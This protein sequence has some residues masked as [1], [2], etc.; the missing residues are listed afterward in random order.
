M[1][2]GENFSLN[3]GTDRNGLGFGPETGRGYEVGIAANLPGV[4]VAATWFDIRKQAI[5]TTDPVDANYLAPVGNLVSRGIEL[6]ASARLGERWQIVANYA[7]LDAKADDAAFPTP[8]VL[9]VPEHS[10]T[11]LVVHRIPTARGNWQLSGGVAYVGDRAG[12]LTAAPVIL[13]EYVKVKA[14]IEAPLAEGLR[15]RLE[16]D[17]LLNERYAA[18]SYSAL[19]IYPGAPRTLRASIRYEL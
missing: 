4:D 7:W 2:W 13:P 6:D 8:A 5:L 19:W 15:L 17:N 18:S 10:G 9:N 3:T 12:S 16:A 14:A 1:P 11:L